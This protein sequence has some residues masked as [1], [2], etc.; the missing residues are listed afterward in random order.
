MIAHGGGLDEFAIF[1]FP[2]AFGVGFWLLTR[3]KK[4]TDEEVAGPAPAATSAGATPISGGRTGGADHLR[5]AMDERA[6]P[7]VST[8][9]PRERRDGA[10]HLRR[11]M[12]QEASDQKAASTKP[13]ARR[14]RL[15]GAARLQLLMS[16]EASNEDAAATED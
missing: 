14:R 12:R 5:A 6:S 1:F 13:K 10:A 16:G 4:P 8:P 15:D 3:Q 11:A 9:V 7:E 2:V